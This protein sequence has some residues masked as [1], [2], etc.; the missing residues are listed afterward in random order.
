M[1][2]IKIC[3]LMEPEHALAV[4]GAGA[5]FIGMVFSQPSRRFISPQQ[6]A[7]IARAVRSAFPSDG[8]PTIVGVFVNETADA[9]NKIADACGLD[10]VQ[11]SGDEPWELCRDLKRPVIKAVRMR[12]GQ[13]YADLERELKSG[14]SNFVDQG[15][16]CLLEPVVPGQYG[17][18][19]HK[20]DWALAK[21]VVGLYSFLLAGGLTPENVAE[22]VRAVSP[23]GVDV[24]SG[25][26]S[27]GVKDVEKIRR[28]IQEVRRADAK[29]A[30]SALSHRAIS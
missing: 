23:W 12:E 11:L 30:N 17:G 16:L 15:S 9:M 10:M 2:K 22:A 7:E 4:A 13:E 21:H 1:T 6:G 24:S 27:D 8:Q 29:P 5:D 3:G 19:G 14:L 18:T 26:E 20:V 25:V 28:F